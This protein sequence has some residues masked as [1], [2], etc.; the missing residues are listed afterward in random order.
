MVKKGVYKNI[1]EKIKEETSDNRYPVLIYFRKNWKTILGVLFLFSIIVGLQVFAEIASNDEKRT[2]PSENLYEVMQLPSSATTKEIKKKFNQLVIEYHPDKNPSCT[3]CVLKFEKIAKAFEIL[4]DSETRAHYDQSNGIIEP[5][6]SSSITLTNQ[7]YDLL[8]KNSGRPWI[9]Q[10]YKEDSSLSQTFSR[11]WEEFIIEYPFINFGRI[12]TKLGASI[13]K[14]LPFAVLELPLIFSYAPGSDSELFEYDSDRSPNSPFTSFLRN[15]FSHAHSLINFQQLKNMIRK[16]PS[17]PTLV[18]LTAD[19]T[20][21]IFLYYSVLLRNFFDFKITNQNELEEIRKV[22]LERKPKILYFPSSSNFSYQFFDS[23][24]SV[25]G[26]LS[27]VSYAKFTLIPSLFRHSF[28]DFCLDK[29]K[30]ADK[31]QKLPSICLIAIEE[32]GAFDEVIQNFIK[33][34]Q[35]IESEVYNKIN[36]FDGN[37]S[38]KIKRIQFASISLN[39]NPAFKKHVYDN[40]KRNQIKYIVFVTELNI[41]GGYNNLYDFELDFDDLIHAEFDNL[42]PFNDYCKNGASFEMLLVNENFSYLR[43]FLSEIRTRWLFLIFLFF[44]CWFGLSKLKVH[45]IHS[46]IIA[47]LTVAFYIS[48]LL[49]T[50]GQKDKLV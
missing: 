5:I 13:I 9:I 36:E 14:K 24:S 34:Q 45:S 6:R 29:L 32:S 12:H 16:T 33:K 50:S 38:N 15:S 28:E 3:D 26:T 11:F 8:V 20:P 23:Q 7:N 40:L 48:F 22:F 21:V 37:F 2:I 42:L 35:Q 25:K 4:G 49:I 41:I 31:E 44:G 17:K 39:K 43:C 1:K 27:A 18:F 46:C 30:V 19:S 10:I 47:I